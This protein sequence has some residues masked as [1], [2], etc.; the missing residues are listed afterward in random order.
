MCNPPFYAS[1]E[2]IQTSLDAKASP[3]LSLCT[4]TD[5]ELITPG[6]ELYFIQQYFNESLEVPNSVIRWFTC[7]IG[8]K[9]DLFILLEWMKK[10]K[11][12][13]ELSKVLEL[14]HF[15]FNLGQTSRWILAWRFSW[16]FS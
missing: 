11:K 10:R 1:Q 9:Q 5:H 8:K 13:L 7:L 16:N 12:E 6:G 2:Q 4:G 15:T 3:P 14:K